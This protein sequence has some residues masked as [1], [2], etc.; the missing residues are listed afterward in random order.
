MMVITIAPLITADDVP[1]P[2]SVG[3][4]E[5][6]PKEGVTLISLFDYLCRSFMMDVPGYMQ[7]TFASHVFRVTLSSLA[8][9][10]ASASTPV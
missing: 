9:L 10:P 2:D 3:E 1:D 8:G 4:G 7:D 5:T 6:V